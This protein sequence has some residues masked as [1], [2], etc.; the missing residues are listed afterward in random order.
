MHRTTKTFTHSTIRYG[1]KSERGQQ[2][3]HT[4]T[5]RALLIE[6]TALILAALAAAV[7]YA[8]AIITIPFSKKAS[9]KLQ[10]PLIAVS[11]PALFTQSFT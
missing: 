4:L 11:L 2:I 8:L 6:G 9:I 10:T 3:L 5:P 1:T 7:V